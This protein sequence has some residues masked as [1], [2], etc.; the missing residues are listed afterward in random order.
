MTVQVPQPKNRR[1]VWALLCCFFL[2]AAGC[3]ADTALVDFATLTRS[4]TPNDSLACPAEFCSAKVDFV[5]QAVPLSAP[6]LAAKVVTVIG[7][8]PRTELAMKDAGGLRL[9]FVQRSRLF[10]FPD[11]VNVAI[12]P[13]DVGHATIAVYSRSN[14]GYGDLGVNRA[15][16]ADWLAKLGLVATQAP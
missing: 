6:E 10:R 3:S 16:V 2:L 9:V 8:E 11:T 13:V 7:A 5:T 4:M 14:Y 12:A 1:S 15:R